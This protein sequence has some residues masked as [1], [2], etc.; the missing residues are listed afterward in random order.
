M[1]ASFAVV[2]ILSLNFNPNVEETTVV[3]DFDPKTDN[4]KQ[5][6]GIK[7][8]ISFYCSVWTFPVYTFVVISL[9][10]GS[11]GMYIPYINLVKYCEDLGITAQKASRLF[12]F[13]G[14]ASSLGRILSG[15][16]CNNQNVNPVFVYQSSLFIGGVSALLLPSA[17]KYWALVVFSC[18][19]GLSDGIFIATQCYILLSCVDRKRVT[20]SFCILNLVYSFSVATG[21]P[22]AG[23]MADQTGNYINSFYMTGGVLMLAFVIPFA[24][25]FIKRRKSKVH[26]QVSTKMSDVEATNGTSKAI[27]IAK[28]EVSMR[29][30][31]KR[32][33]AG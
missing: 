23:L 17:T 11:F 28:D 10:V 19:Y 3:E 13:I 18:A 8:R 5:E 1:T 29:L 31:I 2:C 14:L 25:I 26:S 7:S 21:G 15:K 20:A 22:I 6:V 12:I 16:L 32:H 24:L 4:I 30:T 9:M 33:T 27:V